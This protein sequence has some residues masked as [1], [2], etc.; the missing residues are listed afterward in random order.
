MGNT[1]RVDRH[2]AIARKLRDAIGLA[3]DDWDPVEHTAHARL[4]AAVRELDLTERSATGRQNCPEEYD[5][6]GHWCTA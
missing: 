2:D 6:Q 4:L 5:S 1:A 3:P